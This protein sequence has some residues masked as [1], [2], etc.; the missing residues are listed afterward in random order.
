MAAAATTVRPPVPIARRAQSVKLRRGLTLL[1]MSLVVPGSAQ[2]AA[3]DRRIGRFGL[4]MWLG[5]LGFGLFVG[6]LALLARGVLVTLITT[7]WV[8][9]LGSFVL[10]AVGAVWAFM[11]VNAWLVGRPASM[12]RGRGFFF[13]LVAA[14]LVAAVGLGTWTASAAMRASGSLVSSVFGGGGESKTNAGRINVLLIGADAGDDREGTRADSIMVAS[15]DA[16]TGRTVLFGLPRN[17]EDVPFP[18]S[19]PLK[20]LYPKGYGCPTHECMLNAIYTLGEQHKNLYPG[21]KLPGVQATREAVEEVL[22][23]KINYFAMVDMA[24]FEALVD[25]VGGVRMD[26]NKRTPIGGEGGYVWVEPQKNLLMNGELALAIARSRY[27]SS[28]YERMVRQRCVLNSMLN[29]LD[30]F[31]VATKFGQLA[32]ATQK[33][34]VTD[35]PSAEINKLAELALKTRQLETASVSFTPPLIYP[36]TPNFPLIRQTVKETISQSEALDKAPATSAQPSAAQ[37]SS[38]KPTTGA[39]T[40]ATA[41]GTAKATAPTTGKSTSTKPAAPTTT[42]AETSENVPVDPATICVAR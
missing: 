12:G 39:T 28:D 33:G 17:M 35:V 19:S 38:A 22:G 21:V 25:A 15:I 29:Q 41:A 34:V 26:L 42:A 30:P 7:G 2:L 36:G 4:R 37:P 6:V 18:D 11:L 10:L 27:Q 3:G 1:G 14:V 40:K 23:L 24:G 9:W 31:T 8:L 13:T 20:K 32:S 5:L 16:T